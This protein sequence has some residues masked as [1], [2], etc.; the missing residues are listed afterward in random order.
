MTLTLANYEAIKYACMNF[1]YA[2]RVPNCLIA[3]NVYQDDEWCGVIAYG[4]GANP[5]IAEPYDKWTGQVLEL[6]RVALN[7]KQKTTSECVALSL[8]EVK[9]YCPLVDLIVS[10]AD[11]D[12]GHIGTL[13][14]ATNWVYVGRMNEGERGGF[15]I[16]GQFMHSRSV[17][18]RRG[19]KNSLEWIRLHVDPTATEYRTEGK[20]KYLYPL[21]KKM[22]KKILPLAQPYPKK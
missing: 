17:G 11:V 18:S 14:Q 5:N 20:R 19:W 6:L 16:N 9:K 2:K 10:Y 1:H 4:H 21:N 8:K 22:R 15:I 3:F 7:G 12:Q 13:Y